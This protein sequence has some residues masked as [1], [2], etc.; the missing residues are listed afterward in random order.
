MWEIR[1]E[2]KSGAPASLHLSTGN[3]SDTD[4]AGTRG[5]KSATSFVRPCGPTTR[6]RGWGFEP[7]GGSGI[8][9]LLGRAHGLDRD[10]RFEV[11]D[12]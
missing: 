10:E 3:R 9:G 1:T 4:R 12:S 5:A 2:C 7:E 8:A 11:T 6:K